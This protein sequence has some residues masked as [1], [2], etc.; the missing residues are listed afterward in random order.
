MA[1]IYDVAKRAR[2][3]TAT[4]SAVLNGTAYVSPELTSRVN[5]AVKELDYTINAIA[6]G[7]QTRR[8]NMIGMLVPDI[9]EPVYSVMVKGVESGLKTAGCS[10]LLGSTHNQVEEQSRYLCMLRSKQVDGMLLYSPSATRASSRRWLPHTGLSSSSP[11][12]PPSRPTVS[13][14]TTWA[15]RSRPSRI[16]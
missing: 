16:C 11:A 8:T 5:E 13:W 9:A 2:V 12:A 15:R 14:W 4:V 6:R 3:S 1:T 7:L 10:L